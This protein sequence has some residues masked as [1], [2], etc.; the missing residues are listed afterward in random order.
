[1]SAPHIHVSGPCNPQSILTKLSGG[2][3]GTTSNAINPGDLI[4]LD[5]SSY[6]IP[7]TSYAWNTNLATTQAAMAL[8]FRG[9]TDTRSRIA[10]ADPRDSHINVIED[11]FIDF[12]VVSGVYTDGQYL[13]VNGTSGGMLEQLVGVATKSLAVAIVTRGSDGATVTTVRGQ[14][15]NTPTRK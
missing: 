9:I 5:G 8:V 14:L 2:T 10:S 15:V 6:P 1:M 7:A 13:G 12:N 11:G 4:F 3:T